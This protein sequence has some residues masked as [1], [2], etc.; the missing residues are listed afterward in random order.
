MKK[1]TFSYALLFA[2]LLGITIGFSQEKTQNQKVIFGKKT[3]LKTNPNN[4][5]IRCLSSEYEKSLQR[6]NP[7]RATTTDF[8]NWIAPQIAR[9]KADRLTGRE[10]NTI[11]TIPVVVHVI[12]NGDAIG[13]NENITDARVLSQITVLNQDFRKMV[14]TPGYNTNAVGA[15]IEIQFCMAQTDPDGALTTGIDRV[16]LGVANWS[17]SVSVEGTLKPQTQWDPT[18]YFN[19][20][21][22]QFS[23]SSSAE[24]YGTLGYAQ[25]PSTSGLTGL[26]SNGGLATTDGVIIDYRCF[27]SKTIANVGTYYTDYDKG[28]T[29]TH[30]IG[31]CFGLRHIWGDGS[32]DESTSA[33]DCTASDYCADTPQAGWEHYTCGTYD[34]CP[35]VAGSDMP[36]NYMDYT[37]DACM[38]I[39]TQNQKDRIQTV[40]SNS[41][42]RAS[43]ATSTACNAGQTYGYN[44]ALKVVNLNNTSCDVSFAPTMSITNKGTNTLTSAI[45]NYN[46]D[47]GTN[48][49][50]NWTG[51]LATN[52]SVI[53]TL[54]SILAG[55]GSHT[56][57]YAIQSLNGTNTDQFSLNDTKSEEISMV[58]N[59][60][61]TQVTIAI[62]RDVY[63]SE[64][65][66]SLV[67]T[68]TGATVASGNG[69][70]DTNTYLP[71]VMTQTVNVVSANCYTFTINDSYGDG[72]CCDYGS[73]YYQLK[74]SDN[75]IIA[76][77]GEFGSTESKNFG[78]NLNLSGESYSLLNSVLLYPNPAKDLITISFNNNEYLPENITVYNN[79]G[80]SVYT[81]KVSKISDLTF[82]V[83]NYSNGMY[84]LKIER[85]GISKTIK[86]LKN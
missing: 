26:S 65:T 56:F 57:N 66:W 16:N 28:R 23:S 70:S 12:H 71:A 74:T 46:I 40:I 83:S 49:T 48:A 73:G 77:G 41:P 13:S 64:T 3:A 69:Y 25:F 9:I 10:A 29:A 62:Q 37:P 18:R 52:G 78:I 68:T 55:Y 80:Q 45:I 82:N 21:V 42:R 86:F 17:T 81:M 36:E 67:N 51:S 84:F 31:H 43:L 35:S 54:P 44:G 53:F 72:I 47:G 38:N 19:I 11:I 6:M 76:S 24:L 22:C 60:N 34:T 33:P 75:T 20:W 2:S 7:N 5:L 50:Y 85:E 8:E 30:E 63:G 61:T 4:G 1:T 59:F 32:G 14:G 79:L 39:F 58:T 15:D 27:G